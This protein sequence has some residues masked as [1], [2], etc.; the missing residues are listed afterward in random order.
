MASESRQTIG[1]IGGGKRGTQ[2]FQLFSQSSIAQVLFISDI[3]PLA[4]GFAAARQAGV[5]T[6]TNLI[7]ALKIKVDFIFEVTGQADVIQTVSAKIDPV[8]CRLITHDM[9]AIIL[10]VITENNQKV[11]QASVTEIQQIK[12]EID[13]HLERLDRFTEDIND[14]VSEMNMLSINARIEAARVGEHGKGFE[15]VAA[16]MGKSSLAVEKITKDIEGITQAIGKTS[17][18]IDDSLKRLI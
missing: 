1:I 2:I 7:E 8:T 18:Q 5:P 11:K 3:N 16:E 4:P 13:G 12:T 14:V 9:T 15:V 17:A 6:F 10:Q